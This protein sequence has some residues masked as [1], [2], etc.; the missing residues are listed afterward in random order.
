MKDGRDMLKFLKFELDGKESETLAP[1][2]HEINYFHDKIQYI[3]DKNFA[4]NA[5]AS[6]KNNTKKNTNSSNERVS[7]EPP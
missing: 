5:L 4:G 1:L 7:K 6:A 3:L 2:K